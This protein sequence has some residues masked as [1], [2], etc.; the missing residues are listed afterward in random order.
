[1]A[2]TVITSIDFSLNST[3]ITIYN[4]DACEYKFLSFVNVYKNKKTES[5]SDDISG[6]VVVSKYFRSPIKAVKT[7]KDGLSGWEKDHINNCLTFNKQ[8]SDF[9]CENLSTE[10]RNI[11]VLE[12]YS[13]GSQSDTFI[14]L[15]ENTMMLKS[16]LLDSKFFD[17]KDLFLVTA[18]Q[19]KKFAGG[20]NFDK[21]QLLEAFVALKD[22]NLINCDFHKLLV[23]DANKFVSPKNKKGK[24]VFEVS[25]PIDDIIDSFWINKYF[26]LFFDDFI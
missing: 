24:N 11:I 17:I 6:G 15:I 5:T 2:K 4:C 3:G 14:Q 20:G 1:M 22:E 19:V 21:Y 16:Y 9:I 8:L 10:N 7:Q 26:Q 18:P 13:Y 23:K 12:N 25:T